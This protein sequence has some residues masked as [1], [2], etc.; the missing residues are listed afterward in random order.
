MIGIYKIT[1]PK[2]EIYIGCTTDWGR[3]INEYKKLKVKGQPKIF[4]SL[5]EF[6]P[7]NHIFEFIE[8]CLV[9]QLY[10]REIY[11]TNK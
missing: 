11:F 10:E 2:N 3:R 6:G 1:N 5:I 8:E 4:S 7:I 9:E